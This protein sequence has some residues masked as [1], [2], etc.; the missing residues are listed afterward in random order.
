MTN[1][2]RETFLKIAR[3]AVQLARDKAEDLRTGAGYQG[4]MTDHGAGYLEERANIWINA[5]TDVVPVPEFLREFWDQ[6][7]TNLKIQAFKLDPEWGEYQ[8][9]KVKFDN[10]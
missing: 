5:V 8:R 4:A 10:A 1:C 2:D 3:E 6:A 9:L 7:Q